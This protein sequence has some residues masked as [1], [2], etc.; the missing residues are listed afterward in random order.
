MTNLY[1]CPQ[2]DSPEDIWILSNVA[3]ALTDWTYHR[4]NEVPSEVALGGG[5]AGMVERFSLSSRPNLLAFF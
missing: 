1:I 5:I 2:A 4:V 3:I